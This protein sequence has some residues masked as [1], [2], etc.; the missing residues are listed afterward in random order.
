ML[1]LSILITIIAFFIIITV[2]VHII[3]LMIT[4]ISVDTTPQITAAK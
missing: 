3:V 4:V 1:I 2:T